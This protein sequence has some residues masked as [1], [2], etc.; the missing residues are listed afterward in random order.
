MASFESIFIDAPAA[1]TEIKNTYY[2]KLEDCTVINRILNEFGLDTASSHIING[3]VPQQVK[4]GETP[5][6]C[7]GKLLIIDGGFAAAYHDTST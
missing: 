6:K 2:S 3:H 7:G 4:K 1:R 5:V